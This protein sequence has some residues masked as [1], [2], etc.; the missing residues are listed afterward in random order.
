MIKLGKLVKQ[1]LEKKI[2][3]SHLNSW[4][5]PVQALK[6]GREIITLSRR[7]AKEIRETAMKEV[8]H[9]YEAAKVRGQEEGAR[10][11]AK[12]IQEISDCETRFEKHYLKQML[13]IV[14]LLAEEILGEALKVQPE[15][16]L[17]RLKR[18]MSFIF[19]RTK[20]E[21]FVNPSDG[22]L[23]REK[24]FEALA[25][26]EDRG[27]III[28]DDPKIEQ[29]NL[30]IEVNGGIVESDISSHVQALRQYCLK[31]EDGN[32]LK[33]NATANGRE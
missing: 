10:R 12:M 20:C 2:A 16:I 24:L 9:V 31:S 25:A 13:E 15:S 29:G 26:V 8:L 17:P 5:E 21:I 7:E 33:Q 6:M 18:A 3:E 23:L 32:F 4:A 14:F 1:L 28:V 22:V 11:V 27:K 30:R 19:S